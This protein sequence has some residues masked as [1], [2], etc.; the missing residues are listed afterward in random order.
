MGRIILMSLG[1]DC[2]YNCLLGQSDCSFIVADTVEDGSN[3]WPGD[4]A[5]QVGVQ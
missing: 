5:M 4:G 3:M 2:M 1:T